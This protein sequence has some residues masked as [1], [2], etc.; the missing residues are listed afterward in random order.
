MTGREPG[1]DPVLRQEYIF[2]TAHFDH[3]GRDYE[4]YY[5]GADDDA[6]GTAG[7]LEVMRL[8]KGANPR[9]TIA[10]MG[11]SGEEEGLLGS[12]AFLLDPPVPTGAIKADINLDMVGRGRQ[13]E[14]HVMPARREGYVTTLTRNARAA[15]ANCG[16]ALSAGLEDHWQ[17]SD[18]YS[19]LRHGIP[20][21][22]FNTGLHA[23]YHQPTDTP[24]KINYP[25]LIRVVRIVRDLALA[26]ANAAKAP[27]V[28]PPAVWKAWVWG[29]YRTP[30]TELAAPRH[31][32]LGMNSGSDSSFSKK[33]T[34]IPSVL[35]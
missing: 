14:L 10:F 9:R 5:P 2:V 31:P 17:D 13:G 35:G 32:G 23:D 16:I 11:V 4:T 6:S 24:D 1:A 30:S 21:I 8:L 26:T 34:C 25:G 22:C 7:M 15:A 20:A 27:E 12:E 33:G 29:P 28:L 19:F 3:L 18:H